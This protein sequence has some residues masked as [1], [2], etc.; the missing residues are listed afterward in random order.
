[1][2]DSTIYKDVH[3]NRKKILN[4]NLISVLMISSEHHTK[5][6][7]STKHDLFVSVQKTNTQDFFYLHSQV[8]QKYQEY[9][10]A[11]NVFVTTNGAIFQYISTVTVL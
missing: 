3:A 6:I 1:M 2:E 5:L 7:S 9:N 4:K 10:I 8:Y 11:L